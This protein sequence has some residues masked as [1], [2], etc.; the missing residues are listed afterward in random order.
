MKK[1]SLH[2]TCRKKKYE[3]DSYTT[4]LSFCEWWWWWIQCSWLAYVVF[5]RMRCDTQNFYIVFCI[6]VTNHFC[7]KIFFFPPHFPSIFIWYMYTLQYNTEQHTVGA[8]RQQATTSITTTFFHKV[9]ILSHYG[10]GIIGFF[11]LLI[12]IWANSLSMSTGICVQ[13]STSVHIKCWLLLFASCR[14]STDTKEKEEDDDY[15]DGKK[16]C[17]HR[18]KFFY[19]WFELNI[20][21]WR[22]YASEQFP[23]I[24]QNEFNDGI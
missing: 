14:R 5:L 18:N 12:S 1:S 4:F 10:Y 19:Q 7:L 3:S 17:W 8:E 15:N 22:N 9:I 2:Q 21:A 11:S 16:M 23:R 24:Y 20:L 13:E 6:I